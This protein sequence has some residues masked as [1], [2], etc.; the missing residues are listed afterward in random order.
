M[1]LAEFDSQLPYDSDGTCDK[2]D[3]PL[4]RFVAMCSADMF[5]AQC[6]RS[7]FKD[8]IRKREAAY[9][10][11]S[12]VSLTV[13]NFP[14]SALQHWMGQVQLAGQQSASQWD[15]EAPRTLWC[16]KRDRKAWLF[17]TWAAVAE[18]CGFSEISYLVPPDEKAFGNLRQNCTG[19]IFLVLPP[20]EVIWDSDEV[21]PGV[22]T[23]S[24]TFKMCTGLVANC[25][26][27]YLHLSSH[28]PVD[29]S[30]DGA[31]VKR[32]PHLPFYD[33]YQQYLRWK[34]GRYIIRNKKRLM[35]AHRKH[36]VEVSGRSK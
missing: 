30:S 5:I 27:T 7:I 13:P 14:I 2:C 24:V 22:S 12:L 34:A 16:D 29:T 4:G 25:S 6:R 8:V 11:Q 9:V 3:A 18:I 36:F 28:H 33:N 10:A 15:K 23:E 20:M 19:D 26:G 35:R 21:C 1:C 31:L 17:T 32:W